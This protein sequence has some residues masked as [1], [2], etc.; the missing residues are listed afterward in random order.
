MAL[1]ASAISL[2]PFH[3]RDERKP[4]DIA[5]WVNLEEPGPIYLPSMFVNKGHGLSVD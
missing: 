1:K 5:K 3:V 2:Q 4:Q